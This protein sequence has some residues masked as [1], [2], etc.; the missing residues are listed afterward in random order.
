MMTKR[1]VR[2]NGAWAGTLTAAAPPQRLAALISPV[3]RLQ[4]R[5]SAAKIRLSAGDAEAGFKLSLGGLSKK[6][7]EVPM[8]SSPIEAAFRRA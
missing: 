1:I 2:G 5:A 6:G 4:D 3:V 8:R 7:V